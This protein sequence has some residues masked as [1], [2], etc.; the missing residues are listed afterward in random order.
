MCAKFYDKN[1]GEVLR[2]NPVGMG[3][4]GDAPKKEVS[5]R[6]VYPQMPIAPGVTLDIQVCFYQIPN[7]RF[8]SFLNLR[9]LSFHDF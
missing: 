2:D 9:H 5:F 8:F 7:I 4:A 6:S 3:P 1:S